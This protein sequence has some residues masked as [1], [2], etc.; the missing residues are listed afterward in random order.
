MM[1]VSCL[2]RLGRDQRGNFALELAF[3]LPVLV[4][5]FLVGV[6]FTRYML[7]HQKVERTAATIADLVSQSEVM[8][9]AEMAN[10]FM[11]T[12]YV[13]EP[14][15]LGATGSV[16]V[17][18]ISAKDGGQPRI[19]WQRFYGG[20]GN[21]SMFGDEGDTADLPDGF[22]VRDGEALVACEAYYVYEPTIIQDA[23]TPETIHRWSIFRPRFSK[24]EAIE[25]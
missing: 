5:L 22:V 21:A 25:P 20:G 3:A 1:M 4:A 7:I 24:L 9:E 18:S 10:L 2:R 19:N 14:F 12:E 17:S 11:A 13:M 23:L 6:E 15:E 8:T 16:I